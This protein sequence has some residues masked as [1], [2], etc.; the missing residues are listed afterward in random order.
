MAGR[1]VC[2][3]ESPHPNPLRCK[4]LAM[5]E[6]PECPLC[7]TGRRARPVR[8]LPFAQVRWGPRARASRK[9]WIAMH[10]DRQRPVTFS[11]VWIIPACGFPP[12]FPHWGLSGTE[13]IAHRQ[14]QCADGK[15]KPKK[16]RICGLEG[17]R[18]VR[19]G[20]Q[21]MRFPSFLSL[22]RSCDIECY[23]QVR[24]PLTGGGG[25]GVGP[26]PGIGPSPA[27]SKGSVGSFCQAAPISISL[28]MSGCFRKS[29]LGGA[30]GG[31]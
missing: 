20:H 11:F 2:A 19:P 18:Q 22:A 8:W 5:V 3:Q 25:G 21:P 1:L 14:S 26:E 27:I 28:F 23:D 17:S 16:T 29:I 30:G 6:E 7:P 9:D 13:G 4:A 31:G 24:Q 10:G 12:S 15:Q